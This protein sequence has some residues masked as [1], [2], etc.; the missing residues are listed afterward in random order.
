V[1]TIITRVVDAY[2][3]RS[4]NPAP[5]E[6]L[7]VLRDGFDAPEVPDLDLRQNGITSVIWAMGY[8]FDFSLVHLPIFDDSGFPIT[9]AGATRLPGLYFAG[10]PWLPMQKNGHLLGMGDVAQS[11]AAR[12]N[13]AR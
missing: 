6:I 11:I 10:M 4:S 8:Q 2:I 3:A 12:I 7:P 5:L 1:E 9:E 13:R